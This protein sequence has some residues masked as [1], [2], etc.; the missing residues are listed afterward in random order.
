MLRN[1]PHNGSAAKSALS[2][3]MHQQIFSITSGNGEPQSTPNVFF[4]GIEKQRSSTVFTSVINQK[5]KCACLKEPFN[6]FCIFAP[7]IKTE[8]SFPSLGRVFGQI[9]DHTH[10][11]FLVW[12]PYSRFITSS[13]ESPSTYTSVKSNPQQMLAVARD[14]LLHYF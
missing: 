4:I 1:A 11:R 13:T 10:K 2:N 3:A 12:K 7:F 9:L 6:I 5:L 14:F 8:H